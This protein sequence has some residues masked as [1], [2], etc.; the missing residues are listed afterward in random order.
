MIYLRTSDVPV[1]ERFQWWLALVEQ[2]LAPSAVSSPHSSDFR[3][4][5]TQFDLGTARVSIL[6]FPTLRATR[7]W[8]MIRRSD[9]ELWQVGLIANGRMGIEQHHGQVQLSAGDLVVYDTS[10]PYESQVQA[11]C[12]PA[13]VVL[14]DLPKDSLPIPDRAMRSLA[15]RSLPSGSGVGAV[16]GQLLAHVL[17]DPFRPRGVRE[18][19][20]L[21]SALANLSAAFLSGLVQTEG[22]LPP[23][24]RQAA[25][26][27]RV[28]AFIEQNLADARL[29]PSA[30]ANAHNISVRYLHYLFRADGQTVGRHI[31]QR[32]L[33]R[34][35]LALLNPGLPVAAVGARWGFPDAGAFSRAFKAAYGVP[36]GEYRRRHARRA[37]DH[38]PPPDR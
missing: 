17:V 1:A 23:E 28:R 24:T 16:F 32:R 18:A 29:S 8:Q 4:S 11:D 19:E 22:T 35:R 15:A 2:T 12:R 37:P 27:C 10:H 38:A 33:D 20:H 36:P 6:S 21:G 5:A 13:E 25:L 14:M 34:C 3:A 30:I 9:P 26:L 7:T 31:R